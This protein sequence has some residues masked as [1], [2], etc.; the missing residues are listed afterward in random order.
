M[1]KLIYLLALFLFSSC[2]TTKPSPEW[3]YN[4]EY[5]FPTDTYIA[6]L[7][8]GS[9]KEHAKNNAL[10]EVSRYIK[11]EVNSTIETNFK[12]KTIDGKNSIVK[13]V[14]RNVSVTSSTTLNNFEYTAPYF[15]RKDKEWYC[16]AYISREKAWE[17][18]RVNIEQE[19]KSFYSIYDRIPDDNPLKAY[20][21]SSHAQEAA[22]PFLEKL[23]V[24][25]VIN[26]REEQN[27]YSKDRQLIADLPGQQLHYKE[28][29]TAEIKVN[30]DAENILL[31]QL[32]KEFSE[33]G[34]IIQAPANSARYFI[35]AEIDLN[36]YETIDDGDTIFTDMPSLFLSITDGK[37]SIYSYSAR[38]AKKILSFSQKDVRLKSV[39]ALTE[40]IQSEL[41]SD[42]TRKMSD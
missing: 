32:N 21:W 12:S 33:L 7:G 8:S 28:Q 35:F 31:A 19:K 11:T 34:F 30:N 13:D 16:I 9:S 2:A 37:D 14:I 36:E 1:L 18:Y 40:I 3:V 29:I 17:L 15:S 22:C 24:G 39:Q 6:A 25:Y 26:P 10:A 38:T 5:A 41:Q 42:F 23:L 27:K 20:I 4:K